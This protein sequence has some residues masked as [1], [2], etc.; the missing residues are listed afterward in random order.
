MTFAVTGAT[1]HLGRLAI[2]SLLASGIPA[3]E[4]TAI[5]RNP[6]KLAQLAALGVRTARAS[7]DDP[8]ALEAAFAGADAVLLVSGTE[9]GQR[10]RQ[11][12]NA[13]DAAVKAG[14]GRIVYTSVLGGDPEKLVLA[15]EHVATEQ[16][17]LASGLPYTILRNGW[18]NENYAQTL[19]QAAQT[20]VVIG[21][22]GD[23]RV[24]SAARRDY[25]EAAAAVLAGTGHQNKTYELSGDTAWDY[26]T[27]AAVLTQITGR[28][29]VYRDL[30]PEEHRAA[31]LEAGL[32]EG[33]A[34]FLTAL[35]A[36]IRAGALELATGDLSRLI[37]RPTTPLADT[38]RELS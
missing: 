29:V 23:G 6:E 22:A 27:L 12:T 30:S 9:V 18:Y 5:G 11:H 28:E 33:T 14:A 21:S 24:A 25:A 13:I 35:D 26:R 36:G 4:I 34:G 38:L 2:E 3:A 1:G 15:P 16:A 20:G 17:I 10:V 8:S 31:L 32:D 19:A 7:F 37:G